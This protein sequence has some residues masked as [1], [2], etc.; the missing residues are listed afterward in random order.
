MRKP[1]NRHFLSKWSQNESTNLLIDR[2]TESTSAHQNITWRNPFL[3]NL[4]IAHARM[5]REFGPIDVAV[6]LPNQSALEFSFHPSIDTVTQL[7]SY[8]H[9]HF[10]GRIKCWEYLV[11]WSSNHRLQVKTCLW[12]FGLNVQRL[13]W[14]GAG[15]THRLIFVGG[16]VK[17]T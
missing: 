5:F 8:C 4:S 17:R 3:S 7:L 10:Y 12:H 11:Q 16:K 15:E 1:R 2:A 6:Y 14:K 13:P 9:V